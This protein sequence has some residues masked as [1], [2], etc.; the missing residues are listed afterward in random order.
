MLRTTRFCG[1]ALLIVLSLCVTSVPPTATAM[2]RKAPS[3]AEWPISDD[4]ELVTGHA[5]VVG[6]S[7][8][9]GSFFASLAS[10]RDVRDN[11]I[12]ECTGTVVAPDAVLTAGHCAE[13]I[14]T[15]VLNPAS[16]YS[17][18]TNSVDLAGATTEISGVSAVVVDPAFMPRR[19]TGDAALLI[20]ST[21]TTAPPVALASARTPPLH[22]D[23]VGVIAGWG[24]SF[25]GQTTLGA[26]LQSANMLVKSGSWCSRHTANFALNSEICAI[27]PPRHAAGTCNGDSGGPLLVSIS[28]DSGPVEFGLISRGSPVCSTNAPAIFTSARVVSAWVA[29]VI[30]SISG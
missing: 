4:A 22:A 9:E 2:S 20:L 15:N 6:G 11:E 29:A 3:G 1:P 28:G 25:Y 12:G 26:R 18:A 27:H 21:P 7:L 16:G 24:A 5:S 23:T 10:V 8:A 30:T 14:R 19:A 13:N 17:V